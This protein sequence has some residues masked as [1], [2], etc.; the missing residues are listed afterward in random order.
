MIG[1]ASVGKTSI[2]D[3]YINNKYDP[4]QNTLSAALST[5]VLDVTP[6]G[7]FSSTKVKL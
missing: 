3:R 7:H 6:K 5:K 1:D 4:Q 2:V